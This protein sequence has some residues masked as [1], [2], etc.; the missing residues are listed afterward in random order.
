MRRFTVCVLIASFVLLAVATRSKTAETKSAPAETKKFPSA[1][2]LPVQKDM[3]DPLMLPDGKKISSPAEWKAHRA[4]LRQMIEHYLTGT[5]PPP[6]GNV[7]G[8]IFQETDVLDGKAKFQ[9]VHLSFGPQESLGLDVGMFV[10]KGEGPFPTVVNISFYPTP[11]MNPPQPA[12]T[13]DAKDSA[14]DGAKKGRASPFARVPDP[15]TAARGFAEALN[16][17]Y[18][19]CTFQYT[20][21]GADTKDTWHDTGFYAAYPEY[22]WHDLGAWSWA[23]SRCV[24]YLETQPWADKAKFIALGHSRLGKTTLVAGA[25]DDRFAVVAPAGSGCAGTGAFRYNGKARQGKEGLEDV[26]KNFPQWVTPRLADFSNQVEKLP[27]DQNF[28]IAMVA[29]R[30]FIEAEAI[31][32]GACNGKATKPAFLAA[33]PVFEFLGVPDNIGTH[34]RPGGH[35]LTNDDWKAV[36]D[37]AD[38]RL[39]GKP[40]DQK[41]DVFPPDEQL[42]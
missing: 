15:E 42:H 39:K 28:L 29:P 35:A 11:S 12:A 4:E 9:R 17:G 16:R 24:D 21:A 30:A 27:F 13:D 10:P 6:P 33:K 23:M 1:A 31:D 20:Q 38:W 40:T 7:K 14:K 36:L 32:D 8:K 2:D 25:F 19:V 37:F 5:V 34:F 18:A 26:C 3:P 41:F 22:D